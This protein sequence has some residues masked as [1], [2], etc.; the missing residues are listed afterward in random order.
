MIALARS[1]EGVPIS[2]SQLDSDGYL[3]GVQN[4]VIDLKTFAFREGRR[5]DCITK[6]CGTHFDAEAKVPKLADGS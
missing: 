2:A 3:L 1:E 5:E 6:F 4:G